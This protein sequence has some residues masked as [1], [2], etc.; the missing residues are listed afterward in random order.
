MEKLK[1]KIA[2]FVTVEITYDENQLS[3]RE[4]IVLEKL[5]RA[6]QLIDSIFLDQVHSKNYEIKNELMKKTDEVSKL[7]LKLFNIMFGPFDRIEDDEPFLGTEKKPLGANFYPED[8]TKEE[9]EN[10]LKQNPQ[11]EKAFTSEFT[12]IRRQNGKLVAIPYSEYYKEPLTKISNL[13]KEAAD[14]ADNPS[15]KKYLI[16]RADAFLS[17][18]YYQSDM[19]WMDLK[20]HNIEVVIGP[21]EVYEDG[22]FNYKASFESF[23]TIK[24]PVETKKLEVFAKYLNDIEKNLPLDD[25][26][27]N[28]QRGSESPIVVANEVFTAGDTK[29]G[30]QTLA[31]NL[32]NDERV[33]KAKGSKKVMLKNVHEAKFEKLLKPIAEIVLDPSELQYV[34]FDAFFNH[35]LMHE[36]SHGVGPGFITINGKQTEVKKELKESYSTIEECKADIL[37]MYNNIFMIEKGVYPKEMEKQVWV[38]FLAGACRSM[39]FGIGE[40]HGGGNAIIYNYLLEK[41]AYVYDEKNRKV[42]VNFNKIYPALKELCNLVLTIQAEGNYQGAKDLIAKY[43]INSPSIEAM[44]KKLESLPVDIKPVF[45]IEGKLK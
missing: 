27:K 17:N 9:F 26:H 15:L 25:K 31:F 36:M 39:R 3:E 4:K 20:D 38:T 11:D 45:G 24:D 21:Y 30:V 37:G 33:R 1:Q 18:D 2:K 42:S 23:V 5:Y 14:Y 19:D 7:Q 43:A 10:W 8:M 22:L 16:S 29:A 28:Y 13:L 12:V 6:S 44:R 34:T 40:A 35:T 41:G 32:P